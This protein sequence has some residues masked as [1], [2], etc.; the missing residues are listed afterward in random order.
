MP[1][2]LFIAGKEFDVDDFLK[3]IT[4]V[5]YRIFHKG[6]APKTKLGNALVD[7][8]GCCFDVS[9]ASFDDFEKQLADIRHF[10]QQY[11]A[12]IASLHEYKIDHCTI[13]IGI[14][15]D[16]EKNTMALSFYVPADII[17]LLGKL[18]IGVELSVY[19]DKRF[20]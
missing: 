7:Y 20:D 5:P 10:F 18:N 13:D 14:N 2:N 15:A 6:D 16:F 17:S 8:S 19:D 9:K 11:Q 3:R 1:T 12:E 4:L